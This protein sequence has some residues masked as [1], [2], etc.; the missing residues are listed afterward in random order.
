MTGEDGRDRRMKREFLFLQGLAG[1][2]FA[3]LGERLVAHGHGV[4][5]INFNGGDRVCWSLPGALD[6]RGGTE[7]WP[8]YLTNVLGARR[9]TDI[10]LFGDCRPLHVAAI[11][12]ARRQGIQIHVFEEGY[13][14]P[15]FVTIEQGGVNGNSGLPQDPAYYLAAAR[16]L[17]PMPVF[18]MVPTSFRQR[19]IEDLVYNFS[20]MLLKPLFM[21]Y[22]T[23]RPWPAIVEYMG[24]LKRLVSKRWTVPRSNVELARLRDSKQPYFVFPLQLDCDTQIRVHSDFKRMQ[25]AIDHILQSFAA[26][27]PADTLLVVKGHPID[28]GLTDWGKRVTASAARLGISDRVIFIDWA[29]IVPLVHDAAGVVTINSTTG[30]LS[31]RHGVPTIVLGK[32]VYNIPRITHHTGLD[33]FWSEP[34]APEAAVFDAFCRVL[35]DRCL[36]HG[37]YFSER[38]LDLLVA[39]AVA[40]L[41]AAQ[42]GVAALQA[43]PAVARQGFGSAQLA[44]G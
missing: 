6:Y 43:K 9:I 8:A 10:V 4:H 19:A 23:H 24:W 29:D 44:R 28:N 35:V 32:A 31:L 42:P 30:T 36:I 2:F 13:V 5:R 38:G 34:V 41:E 18:P 15:D 21:G 16:L 17:P 40:R 39:G 1:P 22:R 7:G 37:G 33:R 26:H 25:P 11:R 12:L 3:R 14:R 27:A 20:A